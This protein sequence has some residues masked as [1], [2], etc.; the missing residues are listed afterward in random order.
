MKGM[1]SKYL[2]VIIEFKQ[3][4][5]KEFQIFGH[6]KVLSLGQVNKEKLLTLLHY[7]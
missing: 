5:S 1:N 4:Y 6:S 7:H 3:R 2:D